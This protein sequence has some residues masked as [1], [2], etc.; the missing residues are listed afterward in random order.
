MDGF[1]MPFGDAVGERGD[2]LGLPEPQRVTNDRGV[3][4][5]GMTGKPSGEP[6]DL[7]GLD[8]GLMHVGAFDR[9]GTLN[10]RGEPSPSWLPESEVLEVGDGV[11]D[12]TLNIAIAFGLPCAL[13]A[14]ESRHC[15]HARYM[16]T[17]DKGNHTVPSSCSASGERTRRT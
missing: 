3:V 5:P 8:L 16:Y 17:R 15:Q 11:A 13:M 2:A 10:P 6:F 1:R 14:R 7:L 4:L 9:D 12:G